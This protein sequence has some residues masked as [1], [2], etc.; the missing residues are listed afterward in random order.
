MKVKYS[1][2]VCNNYK[3][4]NNFIFPILQ[5]QLC[6]NNNY[7]KDISKKKEE[8]H[9]VYNP[10]SCYNGTSPLKTYLNYFYCFIALFSLNIPLL[11]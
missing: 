6:G 5:I 9:T 1:S 4:N 2:F 11:Y 10:P 8:T 7:K 3:N